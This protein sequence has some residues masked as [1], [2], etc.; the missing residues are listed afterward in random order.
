MH[1]N[2]HSRSVLLKLR[3]KKLNGTTNLTSS[4]LIAFCSET[5]LKRV[6]VECDEAKNATEKLRKRNDEL[7]DQA[8]QQ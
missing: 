1:A 2:R 6:R 8:W 4:E 3:R 5:E 7:E